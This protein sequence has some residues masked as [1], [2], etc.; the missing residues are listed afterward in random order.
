MLHQFHV[1]QIPNNM[2][3][4]LYWFQSRIWESL[5]LDFRT[6]HSQPECAPELGEEKKYLVENYSNKYQFQFKDEI[7]FLFTQE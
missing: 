3:F 7:G 6:N 4:S 2:R 1:I 5:L